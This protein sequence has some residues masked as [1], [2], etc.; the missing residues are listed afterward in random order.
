MALVVL[1]DRRLKDAAR[2]RRRQGWYREGLERLSGQWPGR[3]LAGEA[4]RRP[5]HPYAGDLDLFGAGS[6]FERL[7]LIHI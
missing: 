1:H 7:S 5:E 6:L 3:G 2:E 4:H